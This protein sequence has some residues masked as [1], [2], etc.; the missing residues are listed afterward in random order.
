MT[1]T[2]ALSVCL[3]VLAGISGHGAASEPP[4]AEPGWRG[5]AERFRREHPGVGLMERAGRLTRV[6]G[7]AFAHGDDPRAAAAAFL[8]LNTGMFG[9]AP[10]Q[11]EP[12]SIADGIETQ[13]L[14]Y[15]AARG[16]YKFTLVH[17]RQQLDGIPVYG[18]D[19]RLLVRNEPGHPLVW[20]GSALRELG[21]FEIGRSRLE[22]LAQPEFV[23]ERFDA[24]QEAVRRAEPGVLSFG[25]PEV[26]I[27]AGADDERVAPRLALMFDAGDVEP[28]R[29][30]TFKRRYVADLDDGELL[31]SEDRIHHDISGTVSALVTDGEGADICGP[32]VERPLP[33]VAVTDNSSSTF[34]DVDGGFEFPGSAA[35]RVDATLD[36]V[37]FDVADF[38]GDVEAI[39]VQAPF[40]LLFNAANDDEQ[41]RAQSNAYHE[42][43]RVRDHVVRFNPDY[44]TFD[45]TGI[46]VWV[47]RTDGFCPGNAW[48]SPGD[49]SSPTGYSINF[50]LSSSTRANT[51]FSTVIH[52]EFGHHVVSAGGSG[53]GQYGEGMGDVMG[54]LLMD[55][56]RL[57]VGFFN[58]CNGQLRN[59]VNS[60]Q[61][62]CDGGIHYCGQVI[63]GSAWSTRNKLAVSE[64]DDYLDVLS[65]L[66][67]N[68]V[69][70]HSGTLITPQITVDYLVLDDDD[71]DLLNGTP[72][73][74][75]INAGF[76]AHNMAAPPIA[77][78]MRVSPAASLVAAGSPGD[79]APASLDYTLENRGDAALD[80]SVTAVEPWITVFD[81]SGTLVPG[82]SAVVTVALNGAA[83][84]LGS[85]LQ[86]GNVFFVNETSHDGDLQREVRLVV[87]GAPIASTDTPRFISLVSPAT[88]SIS[89]VDDFCVGDVNV[90]TDITHGDVSEL[91]VEL[92]S[93]TGTTV[94]LHNP[95]AGG[96]TELITTFDDEAGR[97]A[98]GPGALS[99]FIG[100]SSAGTWTLSITDNY[101]VNN[102]NL[103][104]WALELLPCVPSAD[105]LQLTVLETVPTQIDLSGSSPTGAPLTY[106]VAELPEQGALFD[107]NGPN[108]G[109]ILS[110]PYTLL[111]GGGSVLYDP[112]NTYV[113]LDRFSYK[114]NDG[115]D[116]DLAQVRLVVGERQPIEAWNM[117]TDPGWDLTGQW[118]WGEP[119]GSGSK[120]R[121]PHS[122]FTGANVVGYNLFGNYGN[123]IAAKPIT[124]EAIDC[125]GF[126]NV[127]LRFMRWLGVEPSAYD[128]AAVEVSNDGSSWTAVWRHR[129]GEIRETAWSEQTYDISSIADN[130]PTVFI[131]WVMGA[132]DSTEAYP[133]WNIDDVEV[134]GIVPVA[135]S[136]L[137]LT[138]SDVSWS[139]LA[140]AVAYDVVRGDVASLRA[141][142]GDFG[143]ATEICLGDDLAATTLALDDPPPGEAQWVLVR[144]V[145][146]QGA[147]SYESFGP[148]QVGDRD[149]EIGS[150]PAACP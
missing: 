23:A 123:D 40:D 2:A 78:G 35:V 31:H 86:R 32:E 49:P 83:D 1:R 82:E 76:S 45:D 81:G 129:G 11:L 138:K 10:A 124:T 104:G 149:A 72:H 16:A 9:V 88:S 115:Q 97:P 101:V 85:G 80:Y 69:L 148:G 26:V 27:W 95:G 110:A 98:A 135:G 59:A 56:P 47:N 19:L 48:Y 38:L 105:A 29:E 107:P 24:A 66:A 70:M 143:A 96:G 120:N 118:A 128:Q 8:E 15:D 106:V 22:A 94:Q 41:I 119:V 113:G 130:Q 34:S 5:A 112:Q 36:G 20:A 7:R 37:F 139:P 54:I 114:T 136:V 137:S 127:Q 132:T 28:G 3:L 43:N 116:S 50:C 51:A 61:Y 131:R 17:Y 74:D 87:D 146:P 126:S 21:G 84:L 140:E 142:G 55:S 103:D 4:A 64:P 99:D 57:G 121:D 150:A 46:P 79:F 30:A 73:Y 102:G 122:G 90:T 42:A 108:G 13:P 109:E 60:L 100:E 117:D 91:T 77:T 39:S 63:S 68:A 53:Q 52:H 147:M 71:D 65:N 62:P 111:A 12:G 125:T 134:S 44:P 18:A 145:A 58:N 93:P 75:E 33:Y 141:S 133:G 6:Y 14:V 89:V 67:I 25:E 92:A 144:G